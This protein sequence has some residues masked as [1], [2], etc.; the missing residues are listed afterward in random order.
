MSEII[1][2]P[3][4]LKALSE[5]LSNP[6]FEQWIPIT[7]A[8]FDFDK[9]IVN[10]LVPNNFIKNYLIEN[11]N[12][13]SNVLNEIMFI[14][15]ELNIEIDPRLAEK[16]E[17]KEEKITDL[18][19]YKEVKKNKNLFIPR[20]T[21]ENFI[22]G[23]NNQFAHASAL[24]VAVRPSQSFNPLFVFANSGLGKT[25][26]LHAIGNY[27]TEYLETKKV[28]YISCESFLNEYIKSIRTGTSDIFRKKFRE[29][30]DVLLI[31]DAQFIAGK[32]QSQEELFH[33]IS[34]AQE[35]NKQI[36]IAC[37]KY[38]DQI[39]GLD[40][41]LKTRF[42]AGV[43]CDI[44]PPE[45]ETRIAIINNKAAEL[46]IPITQEVAFKIAEI[47]P[48]S[49][50]ELEGAITSIGAFSSFS[51]T[52]ITP[53]L[54]KEI[55]K[56]NK[57]PLNKKEININDIIRKVASHF[58]I[59]YKE[60]ISSH[61]K[62]EFMMPRHIAMYIAKKISNKSLSELAKI[63]NRNNHSSIIHAIEKIEEIKKQD[64]NLQKEIDYITN[65]LKNN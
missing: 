52:E 16:Q 3:E 33:T 15:V 36:V 26:L 41:R 55:F 47:F 34:K 24:S 25:H 65:E 17:K 21:F 35:N 48:N 11:K 43:I 57:L 22:V 64:I 8:S 27:I 63:F 62:K 1:F 49:V 20:F 2:W 44:K 61:R 7:N 40:E 39:E 29:D 19:N 13:L 53:D 46:N 56:E 42:A 45:M 59:T 23:S 18:K 5:R 12:D 54:I 10:I 14:N 58:G 9:K 6:F 28:I 51:N 37:D 31:D 50:R 38:P 4:T 30:Y 32:G 60:I